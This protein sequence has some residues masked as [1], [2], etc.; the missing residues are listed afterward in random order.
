MRLMSLKV[1]SRMAVIG[2]LL[3]MAAAGCGDAELNAPED[4]PVATLTPAGPAKPVHTASTGDGNWILDLLDGRPIFEESVVTLRITGN[5]LDGFDGCNG[6][7]GLSVEGMEDE[8]LVFGADGVFSRPPFA[9]TEKGCFILDHANPNVVM[10]QADAYMSALIRG[11]RYRVA[12]DRLVILDGGGSA[13]LVFVREA[14]LP[15]QPVDL[16]GTSWRLI[17]EDDRDNDVRATTLTFLNERLITG[18]TACRDY[19]ASYTYTKPEGSVRFSSKS[20]LGS[21]ES[22]SELNRG[23]AG[24]YIDFL[25]RAREYSV[26]EDQGTKRLS[27]RSTRSKTLTFE[28][29]PPV[30]EDISDVDWT[31]E[32]F[33]ELRPGGG[34]PRP[35]PVFE[36]TEVTVSFDKDGISGASGC[37]SYSALAKVDDDSFTVEVQS[38]RHTEKACEGPDGLMEQ[39]E[40][41]LDLLSRMTRYGMY[42][43]SLFMQ[44]GD[45]VF[46]LFQAR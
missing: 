21:V 39:E 15:G 16:R 14:P 5:E 28:P 11:E 24:G 4:L 34:S 18:S 38:L 35:T 37:N 29:L 27:I 30:V 7:E 31:L 46:L 40:R 19:L 2:F 13:R 25:S 8:T 1:F 41:Y 10:D 36:G 32:T 6:Y 22:C 3:V 9:R 26:Y 43:D 17:T 42:G 12:G 44:T 20:M 33:V 45:D 23:L